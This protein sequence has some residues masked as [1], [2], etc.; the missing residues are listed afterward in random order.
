[1]NSKERVIRTLMFDYPDRIP[2]QSWMMPD[3]A[4]KYGQQA[5]EAIDRYGIDFYTPEFRDHIMGDKWCDSGTFTDGWGCVWNNLRDGIIGEVKIHPLADYARIK[6]FRAPKGLLKLGWE[7]VANSIKNN[8]GKF[9]LS[10]WSINIFEQMQF[11]R[12]T[13]EL[14][15]DLMEE[16][17]EV[18]LLKEIVFDF[19]REWLKL[20]LKYGIDGVVF[21]DDWGTQNSLLASPV[22]FRKFFRPCYQ[23]LINMCKE[24]GKY[25]FFHSDGNIIGI[26]DD[27]VEMGVD[28]VNCQTWLMGI[29]GISEKYRGKITFWGEL[30]RQK[31]LPFGTAEDIRNEAGKMKELL[32]YKGGGMI[33]VTAAGEECPLENIIE[34]LKCW[35]EEVVA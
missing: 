35:N 4:I 2:V 20:W 25:V 18:V 34:S 32:M 23:E 12:G 31:T 17:N 16:P 1:M 8:P 5:I 6:D 24:K 14:F 29:K 10:P 19:F 13:E 33:G 22:I 7:N 9:I 30:D 28:A 3:V 26:L 15:I 27:F 21:S 11:L